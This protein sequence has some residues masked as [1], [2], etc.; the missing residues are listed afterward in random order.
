MVDS[1]GASRVLSYGSS[2]LNL[3]YRFNWTGPPCTPSDEQKLPFAAT[4]EALVRTHTVPP[5]LPQFSI[6]CA[7]CVST[8]YT[9][10][11]QPAKLEGDEQRWRGK[12]LTEFCVPSMKISK[13]ILISGLPF[14]FWGGGRTLEGVVLTFLPPRPP[15]LC[16]STRF[17]SIWPIL[18]LWIMDSFS[19]QKP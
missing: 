9:G 18:S 7:V 6:L 2:L 12:V 16:H 10:R 15:T 19:E 13:S 11:A 14:A 17:S 5:S 8:V 1:E 3:F 4:P